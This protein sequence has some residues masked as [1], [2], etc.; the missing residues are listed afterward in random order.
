MKLREFT[1]TD[2]ATIESGLIKDV[3]ILGQKS[4]NGREYSAGAISGA[5]KLYENA[6][7]FI[8]HADGKRSADDRF[9]LVKNVRIATDGLRGDLEFLATHPMAARVTEDV[10]RDM[11]L[12][13]LS[14]DVDG[15]A[16]RTA[17]GSLLVE[18]IDKV[19]SVDLVTGAATVT[20]LREQ[21]E[22][23]DAETTEILNL[24]EQVSTLKGQLDVTEAANTKL[25]EQL[26]T[27]KKLLKPVSAPPDPAAPPSLKDAKK[28]GEFLNSD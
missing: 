27:A 24:T 16:K 19:N 14:H 21:F 17:S 22:G 7:V 12:F 18:S 4:R 25:Q 6:P 5:V 1:Q 26:A 11:R 15:T 10:T 20:S 13:G 23:D 3:R 8:N 9:G 2:K 28:I